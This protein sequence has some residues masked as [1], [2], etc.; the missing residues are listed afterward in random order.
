LAEGSRTSELSRAIK[1]FRWNQVQCADHQQEEVAI[2][3]VGLVCSLGIGLQSVWQAIREGRSGIDRIVSFPVDGLPADVAA[4]IRDFDPTEWVR[5]RKALKL[6]SRDSQLAVTASLLAV[7]GARL[8]DAGIPPERIGVVL[9][10]ERISGDLTESL[11]PYRAC[12]PEGAFD[13][14][15]WGQ[16]GLAASAPLEFLKTLPNM[17]SAHVSIACDAQGPNNTLHH[18]DLSAYLALAEGR[19]ILLRRSADVVL[20]GGASARIRP[21][22]WVGLC[23]SRNLARSNGWPA[24]EVCRPFDRLRRGEVLGEGAAVLVLERVPIALA[25]GAKI[26]GFLHG[27]ASAFA[28]R[29][30]EPPR[31][32]A[33]Q[34]AVRLVQGRS[35]PKG[36]RP[37]FMVAQG[38]G[39]WADD[40]YE[41][42][43]WQKILPEIPVCGLKSYFGNL[44]AA[45]GAAELAIALQ[46]LQEGLIPATLNYTVPDPCCP[47]NASAQFRAT[48]GR[49]AITAACTPIGQAAALGISV[50]DPLCVS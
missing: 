33:L 20:A 35:A 18:G 32:P 8:S 36:D 21:Y 37:A 11:E 25:R 9:G 2:T 6:M 22:D 45:A 38:I 24:S 49:F 3:G 23:R 40:Y 42:Q 5:P 13:W 39:T 26:L 34:M 48:N 14:H 46:A 28:A 47:V 4:E 10:A 41:A 43:T 7:A 16:A 44:G 15:R 1:K 31:L 12:C 50:E 27:T 30:S 19:A 17:V 29:V